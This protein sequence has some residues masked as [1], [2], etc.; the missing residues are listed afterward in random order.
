MA[1]GISCIFVGDWMICWK[2]IENHWCLVDLGRTFGRN[3][4]IF[5]GPH[6][7]NPWSNCPSQ[8]GTFSDGPTHY[9]CLDISHIYILAYVCVWANMLIIQQVLSMFTLNPYNYWR[10]FQQSKL[11]KCFFWKWVLKIY[12]PK[13]DSCKMLQH[14]SL[15]HAIYSS[16]VQFHCSSARLI[17]LV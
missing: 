10:G 13:K 9:C 5:P 2:I 16:I 6:R 3:S 17:F 4:V 15:F 12:S 8:K 11:S 7:P 14:K 1:V